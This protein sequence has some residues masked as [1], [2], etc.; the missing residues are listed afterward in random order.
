MWASAV[1]ACVVVVS[2]GLLRRWPLLALAVLVAIPVAASTMDAMRLGLGLLVLFY[3]AAGIEVC[4]IAATRSRRTSLVATLMVFGVPA[5]FLAEGLEMPVQLDVVVL[6]TTVIAWL[7]GHSVRQAALQAEVRRTQAQA[8]AAVTERLRIA[9]ELHD[10]VAH[11]I[12][13]IAIQAGVGRRV[14]DTQPAEAGEALRTIEAASRQTLS[15]LRRTLVAL[16]Q[17]DGGAIGPE[18]SPLAPSPG[19]SNVGQLVAAT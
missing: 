11:S 16:R 6:L 14:I 4:F 12:G 8:Q 7:A 13:I 10:M 19:L 17:A 3:A 5:L 1:V 2:A 15:S 9:R 18:R